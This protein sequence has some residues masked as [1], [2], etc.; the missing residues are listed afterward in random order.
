M[1]VHLQNFMHTHTQFL[2][3]ISESQCLQTLALTNNMIVPPGDDDNKEPEYCEV[4]DSN[5]K[6]ELSSHYEFEDS[7]QPY[8]HSTVSQYIDF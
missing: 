2:A 5:C 8:V 7:D 3:D 4:N 6:V 1:Y